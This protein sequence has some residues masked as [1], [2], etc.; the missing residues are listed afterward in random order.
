MGTQPTG[1]YIVSGA[2]TSAVN[3]TYYE[4]GT[5]RD[6]PAY[7][8]EG[9]GAWIFWNNMAG[10]W[11]MYSNKNVDNMWYYIG[12]GDTPPTGTWNK[13]AGASPAPTVS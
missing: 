1:D 6:K 5:Y 3:G 10:S 4:N 9:G 11:A 8:K 2:G 12:G 13:S 7:E